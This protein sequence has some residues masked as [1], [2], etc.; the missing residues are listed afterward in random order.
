[1]NT[2]FELV[3]RAD[4]SAEIGRGHL[5][6]IKVL[7][8]QLLNQGTKSAIVTID[9]TLSRQILENAQNI[10][11]IDSESKYDIGTWPEAFL[12]VVD[13]YEFKDKIYQ[14]LK[15]KLCSLV[16]IFDDEISPI[17]PSV[18]GVINH[19][20]YASEKN[21]HDSLIRLCGSHFFLLRPEILAT[22]QLM[23][24]REHILICMGGSDP[25]TQTCRIVK[26]VS[27]LTHRKIIAV[28]GVPDPQQEAEMRKLE[29]VE[30][31]ISPENLPELLSNSVFAISGAGTM[32]YELAYCGTPTILVELAEN[33]KKIADSFCSLEAAMCVGNFKQIKDSVLFDRISILNNDE[34]LRMKMASNSSKLID[35]KGAQRLAKSIK[36]IMLETMA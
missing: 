33:Q 30:V 9:N 16:F 24:N 6:R 19:N 5:V 29:K 13:L 4:A 17:P 15:Q 11:F 12:Y 20:I 21:Y 2:K 28:L 10:V 25:E 3:L 31:Q 27:S 26:I 1:V 7:H 14:D 18:N 23:Q 32:A 8:D 36:N 34:I 35:G 22:N